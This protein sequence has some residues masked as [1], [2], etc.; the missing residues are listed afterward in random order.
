[1]AEKLEL[2][3]KYLDAVIDAR[4]MR[5][6]IDRPA[7]RNSM[8]QDMYRGIKKAAALADA[9]P[10]ID[11][12]YIRG[13]DEWFCVGGDMS[14]EA[15]NPKMLAFEPDPTDHHPFRHLERCSKIVV[16]AVHGGCHAGGMDLLLFSDIAV[17][18]DRATF[19]APE[20]LRGIADAQMSARLPQ[21]VGL[22]NAKYLMFTAAQ[23]SAAEAKEI[24]LVAK[25]VPFDELDAHVEWVLEQI[26]LT[27]PKARTQIKDDINRR[28]PPHDINIFKREILNPEMLE[29][30]RAF[31]EKRKP[32]WP[33]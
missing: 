18:S 23:L 3:S 28:L 27:G 25:V 33:R 13:S 31:L 16:M 8:T 29:G 10:E 20:L 6:R 26:R 17:A 7:K 5:I 4:V 2:D 14:G 15:E 21:V 32:D 9:D 11:A 12:I 24:G 30:F 22:Q 19:R 1:M